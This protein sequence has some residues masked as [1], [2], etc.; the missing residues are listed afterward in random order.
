[1]TGLGADQHKSD[2]GQDE[3]AHRN[4][5]D[6]GKCDSLVRLL[7]QALHG[8][9]VLRMGQMAGYALSVPG[10][11]HRQH[12]SLFGEQM[13]VPGQVC[14]ALVNQGIGC[15]WR[16]L[17]KLPHHLGDYVLLGD[18]VYVDLL[19]SAPAQGRRHHRP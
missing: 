19:I 3:N 4:P 14:I 5:E 8:G 17:A 9:N 11:H 2:G 1:M 13:Q 10:P 12:P 15:A 16:D 7:I 6:P 18:G